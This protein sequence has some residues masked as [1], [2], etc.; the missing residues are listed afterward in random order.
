MSVK[1]YNGYVIDVPPATLFDVNGSWFAGLRAKVHENARVQTARFVAEQLCAK[2]DSG[3]SDFTKSDAVTGLW[4]RQDAIKHTGKRDPDVDFD[5]SL[6]LYPNT[7]RLASVLAV[8]IV[9]NESVNRVLYTYP[10]LN[11]YH[12]W[13]N[14]DPE[15]GISDEE[16]A[17]RGDEWLRAIGDGF[18]GA[19]AFQLHCMVTEARIRPTPEEIVQYQPTLASRAYA[20]AQQRAYE[21]VLPRY[22]KDDGSNIMSALRKCGLDKEYERILDENARALIQTITPLNVEGL[23]AR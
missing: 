6:L 22:L 2:W 14:S 13:S 16:W 21:V 19:R 17:L 10:R 15:D 3:V 12:Y 20:T 8:A 7:K 5:L 1:I 11:S 9:D 4:D 18:F 23:K